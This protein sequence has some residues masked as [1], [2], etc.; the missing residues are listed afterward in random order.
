MVITRPRVRRRRAGAH[1]PSSATTAGVA[2][3]AGS[4]RVTVCMLPP[5]RSRSPSGIG[6]AVRCPRSCDLGP[7][8]ADRPWR[9]GTSTIPSTSGT[10]ARIR[11]SPA[12]CRTSRPPTRTSRR[13]SGRSTTSMPRSSGS[14]ATAP[15]SPSGRTTVH[16]PTGSARPL[17]R[18]CTPWSPGGSN[19]CGRAGSSCTGS[20]STGSGRGPTPT[21]TGWPTTSAPPSMSRR[22]AT[23]SSCTAERGVELRVL[24][25]LRPLRDAV[26]ESGYRFSM[27][28]MRNISPAPG[29]G[30]GTG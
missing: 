24:D 5:C 13:W 4:S 25:D 14:R 9:P 19:G 28:R 12:S 30:S 20:R 15:A 6:R 26:I 21:A 17:R 3:T 16:P 2:S 8:H 22:S 23:C 29:G 10:T 1:T 7:W 27:T 11:A 18:V